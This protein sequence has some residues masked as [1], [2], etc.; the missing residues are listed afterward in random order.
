MVGKNYLFGL[1][2]AQ[3]DCIDQTNIS[4]DDPEFAME[5]FRQF[6]RSE[7]Y[8]ITGDFSVVLLGVADEE[9]DDDELE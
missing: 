5:L 7:G 6:S 1:Q 8:T 3:G 9:I 2:N 4:E